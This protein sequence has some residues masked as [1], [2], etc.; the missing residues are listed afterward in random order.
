MDKMTNSQNVVGGKRIYG[1]CKQWNQTCADYAEMGVDV[2]KLLAHP[3][4]ELSQAMQAWEMYRNASQR[5]HLMRSDLE[6]RYPA[7]EFKI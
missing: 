2:L 4:T 1:V 6:T 5:M 7:Y 3:D